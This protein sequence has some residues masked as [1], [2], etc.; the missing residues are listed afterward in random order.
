MNNYTYQNRN[1]GGYDC[2][3]QFRNH[4]YD[5]FAYARDSPADDF[6]DNEN[7]TGNGNKNPPLQSIYTDRKARFQRD[8]KR[9]IVLSRLQEGTTLADVVDVVRGGMLLEVYLIR[10]D[11][12]CI[13]S[14]LEEQDARAFH[15]HA[16]RYDL[17]ILDRRVEIYWAERQ[18]ALQG[19]VANKISIG[20][21]RNLIIRNASPQL[22]EQGIREHADHIHKLVVIKVVFEGQHII[23]KC[24]SIY[25]AMYLK[26]CLKSRALYKNFKIDWYEDECAGPLPTPA[27]RPKK[28]VTARP[29]KSTATLNR[30]QALN[31]DGTED[32]SGDETEHETSVGTIQT[33]VTTTTG[34]TG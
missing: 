21:T 19:H 7:G 27:P 32:G 9:S 18:F 23:I 17:R 8:A 33:H 29:V 4:G 5:A 12:S 30:F 26:T 13:V 14:F 3:F 34:Y 16:K 25:N 1:Q 6:S 2:S 11:R 22:T 15:G 20:A 28:E 31:M 24:N 10:N